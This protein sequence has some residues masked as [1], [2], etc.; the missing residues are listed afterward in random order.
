M[1]FGDKELTV[2]IPSSNR[3]PAQDPFLFLN[4]SDKSSPQLSLPGCRL[5]FQLLPAGSVLLR[6][7]PELSPLNWHLC[8]PW[9]FSSSRGRGRSRA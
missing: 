7:S 8:H 6:I 4:G 3:L 5:G 9:N 1:T 2:D